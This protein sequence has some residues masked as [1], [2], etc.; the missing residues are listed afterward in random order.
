MEESPGKVGK[1]GKGHWRIAAWSTAALLLIAVAVGMQFTDEIDWGIGDFIVAG[2]LLFGSLGA[3]EAVSRLSNDSTIRTGFGLAIAGSLFLLWANGAVGL[4]DSYADAMY[5]VV[6]IFTILGSFFVRFRAG[7]MARIM[8]L[9]A[10]GQ[11]S[12]GIVALIAGIVPPHNSPSD[13]IGMV[14]IF[15]AAFVGSAL[16]FRQAAFRESGSRAV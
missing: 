10:I 6:I 9:T 12:V 7:G 5:P 14:F 15:G 16:L 2:I 4:T 1:V 11:A 8:F 3:Y 13:I